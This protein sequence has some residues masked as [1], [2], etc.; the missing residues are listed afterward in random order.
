VIETPEIT[1][2][3]DGTHAI[4]DE[5]SGTRYAL[6][7]D[8]EALLDAYTSQRASIFGTPVP[9]YEDGAIEGSPPLLS[10]TQVEPTTGSAATGEEVVRFDLFG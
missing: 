6:R 4:T 8:D 5:A 10:I 7:S 3:M 9:S 1:P 2:Y